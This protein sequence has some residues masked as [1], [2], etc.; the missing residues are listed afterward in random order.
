MARRAAWYVIAWRL[1]WVVP[2]WA[3]FMSAC[4]LHSLMYGKR[5]PLF[6]ELYCEGEGVTWSNTILVTLTKWWGHY[7]RC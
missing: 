3:L 5:S 1:L 4:M 2:F 7:E 6:D